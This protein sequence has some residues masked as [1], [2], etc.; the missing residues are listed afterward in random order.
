MSTEVTDTHYIIDGVSYPRVSTVLDLGNKDRPPWIVRAGHL[1]TAAHTHIADYL[2]GNG[3]LLVTGD[4]ENVHPDDFK[5]L[6]TIL[7]SF[8]LFMAEEGPNLEIEGIEQML[9]DPNGRYAGTLDL[10]CKWNGVPMILDWK[11]AAN[12][13]SR[14]GLQ[15]GAYGMMLPGAEGVAAIKLG[16]NKVGYEAFPFVDPRLERAKQTFLGLLDAYEYLQEEP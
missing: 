9:C 6:S 11:T 15:L 5:R 13:S 3:D 12:P 16:K 8:G 4:E 7:D 10:V 2:E 14:W 1:G